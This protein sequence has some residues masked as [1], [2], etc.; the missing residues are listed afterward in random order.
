MGEAAETIR[1]LLKAVLGNPVIAGVEHHN[2]MMNFSTIRSASLRLLVPCLLASGLNAEEL[3]WYKGNTH[4]HTLW[5][6]GNEFPEMVAV[7]YKEKGYDFLALSDHNLLNRGER[8]IPVPAVEARRKV[9]GG[10]TMDQYR[11]KFGDDWIETRSVEQKGKD[12]VTPPGTDIAEGT[13][14][15]VEEVRIKG[16]EDFRG[17]LEKDG[18]FLL[19]EAEEVTDRFKGHQIH[20]N[21]VNLSEP[22]KAQHGD[23]VVDTIRNNLRAIEVDAKVFGK[24]VLA[25][26][27]HPNFHYSL[28]AENLAEVLE[29]RFMEI[30]NGHPSVN[31]LGDEEHPGDEALWDLANTIRIGKLSAP[32]L[33]GVA[34][35]DSHY[36]HGGDV[37]PGRGWIMVRSH[38]LEAD[39]LVGAMKQGRFYAS[40][41]VV[42]NKVEFDREQK[43]LDLNIAPVDGVVFETRFIGTRKGTLEKA[44]EIL[45]TV[46]GLTP[47][48]QMKG[49][50]LFVRAVVT[51]S[52]DHPNPSFRAQHEQAWSQPV[53]WRK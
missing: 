40:S 24:P 16:L 27:N 7:W 13:V 50:E 22:I 52:R 51:S 2:P 18:K 53:G 3:Q 17:R 42:L 45:D 35:D 1:A 41:G 30:Y 14:K 15:T 12:A 21:A 23:S 36:Y 48:Y 20:I 10:S 11:A 29:A 38:G 39:D 33:F 28:T 4:T 5:S 31:H 43:T 46:G 32:P 19:I 6:D 9:K 25:H 8:W 47:S 37:S 49:D 34:A 26:I 44:G